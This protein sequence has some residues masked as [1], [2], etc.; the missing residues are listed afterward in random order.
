MIEY[1]EFIDA[2]ALDRGSVGSNDLVK[3]VYAVSRDHLEGYRHPAD[4]LASGPLGAESPNEAAAL[5][6]LEALLR[7]RLRQVEEGRVSKRTVEGIFKQAIDE[8]ETGRDA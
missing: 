7:D 4:A 6:E 8:T 5:A 2:I 3:T 1:D